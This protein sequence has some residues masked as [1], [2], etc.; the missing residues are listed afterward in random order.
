MFETLGMFGL[1]LAGVGLIVWRWIKLRD[2]KRELEPSQGMA[3]EDRRWFGHQ[4]VKLDYSLPFG[5]YWNRN[6]NKYEVLKNEDL[7]R[8]F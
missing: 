6:F 1:L 4:R 2:S 3:V 7:W 5:L 8:I